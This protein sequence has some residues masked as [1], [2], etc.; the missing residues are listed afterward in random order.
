MGMGR[1]A[2]V[3]QQLARLAE[4]GEWRRRHNVWI[5]T[6]HDFPGEQS[7]FLARSRYCLVLPIDGWSA[8]F[9]DAVL[10]GCIPVVVNLGGGIA[11]PY[12]SMLRL[13][14][15][16]LNV[17][18]SDL[19]NLPT[20][21]KAIPPSK[22]N[23]LRASLSSWWHRIAWLTHPFVKST[24]A[25]T[26]E[27]NLQRFPWVRSEVLL[28]QQRQ[29]QALAAMGRSTDAP[30]PA[31]DNGLLVPVR[32]ESA[33]AI[34]SSADVSDATGSSNSSDTGDGSEAAGLSQAL[35]G[36]TADSGSSSGS[37]SN[38][39]MSGA[40]DSASMDDGQDTSGEPLL[41]DAEVVAEL[42]ATRVWQRD[43]PVDDAFTTLMQVSDGASWFRAVVVQGLLSFVILDSAPAAAAAVLAAGWSDTF[44]AFE[45]AHMQGGYPF[46]ACFGTS[47]DASCDRA[48]LGCQCTV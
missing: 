22:E 42:F 43:V 17:A 37:S 5:G 23:A 32:P 2:L 39:T 20:I 31:E 9:E 28:Q 48:L 47:A 3:R 40:D 29:Q 13:S 1:R 19:P 25:K 45:Y 18:R 12:S 38:D 34:D 46:R 26:V 11:Q 33:P 35:E 27:A 36:G 41:T 8:T 30:T 4:S 6:S 44:T 15:G 14:S 10:H 7:A 24:A 21:L 16:M